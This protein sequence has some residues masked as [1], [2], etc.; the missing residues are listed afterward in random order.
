MLRRSSRVTLALVAAALLPGCETLGYYAQA[1]SG[2]FSLLSRARPVGDWLIDSETP[3]PLRAKLET[4]LAI[5]DYASREL[6]LPDNASY[7]RYADLGRPFA[8]W[9]VVAAPEFSVKAVQS[10]FPVAGCVTYRGFF[11]REAAENYAARLKQDGS[12]VHIYGVPAYSTLGWFDD[13]LLSTFIRYPDTELARLVFH[14][15]AHQRVYV[16]DDTT[17]NES[18]AVAVEEAGVR[19]W[20][21]ATGR[22][23]QLSV[24]VEAQRRKAEFIALIEAAR[25]RLERLY[26]LGI[27]PEAMR[28]RKRAEFDALLRDYAAFKR[29]WGGFAGYDRF[30]QTPN[31]ALLASMAAYTEQVP[32]FGRLLEHE[33]GDLARFYSRVKELASLGKD[34]RGRRL[35]GLK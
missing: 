34:E 10:C 11:A 6:G 13:P 26:A 31:N 2:Q 9:N 30:I 33:G 24:F 20:L 8:V 4:A 32:A 21:A 35:A 15:L 1:V 17:F 16:R 5:R 23:A 14:E 19:R 3:A 25:E 22:E 27:A 7:R 29:S 28:E 18:F 12:D